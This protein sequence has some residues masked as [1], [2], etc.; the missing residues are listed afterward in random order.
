MLIEQRKEV[1]GKR[2][3]VGLFEARRG[4]RAGDEFT[5]V[6]IAGFRR[7]SRMERSSIVSWRL[8]TVS[9]SMLVNEGSNMRRYCRRWL[10]CLEE[11]GSIEIEHAQEDRSS[12]HQIEKAQVLGK[13]MKVQCLLGAL[14][15]RSM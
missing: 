6:R 7:L 14:R 8:V 9:S 5:R 4:E 13:M 11:A 2:R 3:V 15:S 10:T 12:G 1:G